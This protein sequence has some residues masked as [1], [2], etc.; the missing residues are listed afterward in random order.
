VSTTPTE[1]ETAAADPAGQAPEPDGGGDAAASELSV[2]VERRPASQVALTIEAPAGDVDAAVAH[3]IRHLSARFRFPGFRPGKAPAAVI[4]RAVGWPAIAREAVET[5][6]PSAYTRALDQAGVVAVADPQLDVT[7]ELERGRPFRFTAL[8]TV[9][10]EVELGDYLE[11]RVEEAHTVI[12]DERVDEAIEGV[13]RRHADLLEVDRP[14]QAGDVLRATLVMRRGEQPVG[15]EGEERDVELDRDQL[16][17]GLADALLGLSAGESHSAELTLPDTYA[18]EELRGAVV[19]V[20]AAVSSVRERQLPPLDDALATLDGHGETLAELR[21]WYRE[22]LTEVAE[23]QDQDQFQRAV[24]EALVGRARVA[25][26][27]VMVDREVER[28]L[29]DMELRLAGSGLRLDRYLEYTGETMEQ[30]RAVRRPQAEQRVKLELVLAALAEAEGIEIDELDVER[31]ERSLIGDRKVTADQ[32][33]R[34][35][36]AAHR[37]LLLRAAGQ[38]ALEIARGEV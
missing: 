3:A 9:Q 22:R 19:T 13:R 10:P 31:E 24:L 17:P 35:H 33:R 6:V 14:A 1:M 21:E 4:E 26:P 7:A 12:D 18:N 27:D 5:L 32:R 28:Q 20:D 34:I 30:V 15:G 36:M 37:D 23:T 2:S 25:V 38:R 11:L 16:I 8:V 29:R